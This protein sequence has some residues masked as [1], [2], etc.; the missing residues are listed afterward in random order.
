MSKRI[1]VALSLLIA[2]LGCT[3]SRNYY[4][5]PTSSGDPD[6]IIKGLN[7]ITLYKRDS[8]LIPIEIQWVKGRQKNIT[9]S[10]GK[11]PE[12]VN[13]SITPSKGIPGFKT[14]IG[15]GTKYPLPGNYIIQLLVSDSIKT[16]TFNIKLTVKL[17]DNC[18]DEIVGLYY[19]YSICSNN[20]EI[21]KQMLL[22]RHY[23][24][25]IAI[26]GLTNIEGN[27][28]GRV[29]CDKDS[30]DIPNQHVAYSSKNIDGYGK[31]YYDSIVIRYRITDDTSAIIDNCSITIK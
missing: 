22:K 21:D 10:F 30:F 20:N 8:I 31:I 28:Y 18:I 2:I 19:A 15:I 3:K 29:H 1:V 26:S 17:H 14:V 23:D 27:I 6:Y 4:Q 25:W 16:D 9:L 13:A 5:P 7:E 11:L 24:N 12:K